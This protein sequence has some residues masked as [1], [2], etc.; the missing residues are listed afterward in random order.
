MTGP[1]EDVGIRICYVLDF[2]PTYVVRE[3]AGVALAGMTPGIHLP[4]ESLSDGLW[5]RV[6]ADGTIPLGSPPCRDLRKDW[7]TAPAGRLLREAL[8]PVAALF[9]AHPVRFAGLALASLRDGTFRYFLAGV[10][11]AARLGEDGADLLHAHFARDAAHI[12]L[13]AAALLGVPFTVTTHATDIFSPEDPGRVATLLRR[14]AGIHTISE[15]N[16]G[17]MADRYGGGLSDRIMVSRL[18]L[19]AAELPSRT[20]PR[21]GGTPS[22]ACTASGLVP[23]KGVEVLFEACRILRSRGVS[24]ACSVLGS[25]PGGTRLASLGRMASDMGLDG[26]VSLPGL[27]P[28]GEVL[29]RVSGCTA[30]V[31]PAVAAPNGDMD[32]IPVALM[33]A[34]AMGV[35]SISTRMSGIPEL[36][37]DGANGLLVAPGDPEALASAMERLSSDPQLAGAL[38]SA[39]RETVL[40]RFSIE[41]YVSELVSFWEDVLGAH[42]GASGDRGGSRGVPADGPKTPDGRIR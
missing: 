6:L 14:A 34:M 18:G 38:G 37:E 8:P 27:L 41:R 11:L 29:A 30:F 28:S 13:H 40:S 25:D 39:G 17:Y 19:D 7:C 5:E 1:S 4:V 26:I 32:G 15:Y 33:E 22:F 42:H 23:K 10:E 35:P 12:A 2:L 21:P 20:A 36:I 24:F 16:R 9:A 31:L 3:A